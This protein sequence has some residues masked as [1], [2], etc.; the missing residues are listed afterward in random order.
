MYAW[1]RS[2]TNGGSFLDGE[3]G[4]DAGDESLGGG[5]FVAG[6]AVDLASE[7]TGS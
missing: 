1:E 3:R 2:I 5:F 4:V 6:R 7:E